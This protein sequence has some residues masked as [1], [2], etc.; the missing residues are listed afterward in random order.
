MRDYFVYILTN[1]SR[2]LYIGVTSNLEARMD[3][4]KRMVNPGFTR[5]YNVTMPVYVEQFSDPS[6]AIARE[7]QL[8]NRSR[9]KKIALISQANPHW[10]DL[11]AG[12]LSGDVTVNQ[13]E[14]S[15]DPTVGWNDSER[16]SVSRVKGLG[17]RW[18][19]KR[20]RRG[21]WR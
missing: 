20:C 5:A 16:A 11:S 21:A 19:P 8:K 9:A 15:C 1:V 17:R 12:W 10:Q 2:T 13:L 3:V 18:G 6:I 14:R 7:K 4:H